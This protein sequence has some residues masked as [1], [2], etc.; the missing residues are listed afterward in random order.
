MN[1][2]ISEDGLCKLGDFGVSKQ[3]ENSEVLTSTHVGTAYY[4]P[5]EICNNNSYDHKVDIWMLGCLL[6]ELCA[7][8]KPFEGDNLFVTS[9]TT[10]LTKTN[11]IIFF[12]SNISS[13]WFIDGFYHLIYSLITPPQSLKYVGS[14]QANHPERA[15]SFAWVIL[16]HD[17]VARLCDDAKRTWNVSN[18]IHF[19]FLDLTIIF[20]IVWAINNLFCCCWLIPINRRPDIN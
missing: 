6:Y 16:Q 11:L 14:H 18:S 1:V 15:A 10:L 13:P 9:I 19:R 17:E 4:L 12:N 3:L 7:L 20:E 5:P 2:F 8:S